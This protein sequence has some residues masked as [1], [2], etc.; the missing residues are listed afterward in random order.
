MNLAPW[1]NQDDV[2]KYSNTQSKKRIP[3]PTSHGDEQLIMKKQKP[4]FIPHGFPDYKA[5]EDEF[6]KPNED[7]DECFGCTH[8]C[9]REAGKPVHQDVENMRQVIRKSIAKVRMRELIKWVAKEYKRIQLDVN[10]RLRP[11][12][13]ALPNWS[14]AC[15]AEHIRYHNVDAEMQHWITTNELRD[16]KRIALNAC[17]VAN[18]ATGDLQVDDKQGKLYLMFKKAMEEQYKLRPE[19][20]VYYNAGEFVDAKGA[21]EGVIPLSDRSVIDLWKREIRK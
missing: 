20:L 15:I 9:K 13:E 1:I 10:R 12:E 7:L 5:E 2:F 11:G 8:L 21:A 4:V 16:L 14:E 17:V 6:G 3:S 19:N 18:E